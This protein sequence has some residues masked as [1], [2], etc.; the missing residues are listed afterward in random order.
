MNSALFRTP[1]LFLIYNRPEHTR[2]V[3]DVIRQLR[4]SHLYIAADGPREHIPGDR[5]KC[6]ATR[7]VTKAVDWECSVFTL[8]RDKNKS[9][10]FEI[11]RE[12]SRQDLSAFRSSGISLK[13]VFIAEQF[14]AE[15]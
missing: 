14:T 3:F 1:V 12:G 7:E 8:F 6:E 4:P 10:G 11:S 9:T 13:L 5:E 15:C 2:K